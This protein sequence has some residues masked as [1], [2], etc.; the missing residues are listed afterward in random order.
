MATSIDGLI[1]RGVDH[2]T[3]WVSDTDWNEFYRKINE[4]DAIIMGRKTMD[5]CD[6]DFPL[7]KVP[8]I[9][10]SN[11]NSLHK[12]TDR[13]IIMRGSPN[14]IV[15]YANSKNWKDLL[16]IGGTEV[17]T[18]FLKAGLVDEIILSIHPLVIGQGLYLFGDD[19]LDIKLQLI[20]S[21]VIANELVQIRYKIRL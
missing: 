6:G 2:D 18:Q 20:E 10:L 5:N 15:H 4:H 21:K 11:N 16:L 17:N 8:N 7:G 19:L 14:D 12:E 9:V 1:S 13:L 3:T